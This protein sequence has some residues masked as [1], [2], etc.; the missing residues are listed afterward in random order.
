MYSGGSAGMTWL[1]LYAVSNTDADVTPVFSVLLAGSAMIR[2][3]FDEDDMR[4]R[5]E[6]CHDEY[7]FA[8]SI[9][10]ATY[11]QNGAPILIYEARASTYPG[12]RS[13]TTDT[14]ESPLRSAADLVWVRD[15]TCTFQ[16][17]FE[18]SPNSIA[19]AYAPDQPVPECS[20]YQTQ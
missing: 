18:R 11:T 10:L 19:E 12:V 1:T 8:G 20:D 3:C 2:A 9:N 17:T 6:A 14:T 16:R 4:E 5:F 15:D 13:R 7:A